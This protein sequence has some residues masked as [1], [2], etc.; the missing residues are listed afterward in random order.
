MFLEH[1]G[2]L[3]SLVWVTQVE[4]GTVDLVS[5]GVNAAVSVTQVVIL[6]DPLVVISQV[7]DVEVGRV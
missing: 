5:E 3:V 7:V 6:V 1:F 2:E 4:L